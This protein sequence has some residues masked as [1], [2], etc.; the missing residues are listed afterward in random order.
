MIYKPKAKKT[1]E[2]QG[3][4]GDTYCTL[5]KTDKYRVVEFNA[6]LKDKFISSNKLVLIQNPNAVVSYKTHCQNTDLQSINGG[7]CNGDGKV[8]HNVFIFCKRCNKVIPVS[9]DVG[10]KC[11]FCGADADFLKGD[12]LTFRC[13]DCLNIKLKDHLDKTCTVIKELKDKIDDRQDGR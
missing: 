10:N 1:K 13:G 2:L 5:T 6:K 11:C 12:I 9:S 3:L 8:H 4:C 7:L